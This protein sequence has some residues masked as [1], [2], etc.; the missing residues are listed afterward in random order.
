MGLPEPA[1]AN[2][3]IVLGYS[4]NAYSK[5]KSGQY[6]ISLVEMLNF[7]KII[8]MELQDLLKLKKESS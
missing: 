5:I 2:A 6:D 8:K 7:G 1:P 3:A 4:R